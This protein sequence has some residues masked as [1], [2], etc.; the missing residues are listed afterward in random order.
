MNKIVTRISDDILSDT[1]IE[2]NDNKRCSFDS[3]DPEEIDNFEYATIDWEKSEYE[4]EECI[5]VFLRGYHTM[6]EAKKGHKEV[7]ADIMKNGLK[8]ECL[9]F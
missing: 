8:A 9:I 1:L 7:I 4:N 3:D 5:G 6:E 2:T